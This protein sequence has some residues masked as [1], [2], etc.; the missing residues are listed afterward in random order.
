M[1]LWGCGCSKSIHACWF[2]AAANFYSVYNLA[3]SF[4]FSSVPCFVTSV[5]KSSLFVPAKV[6]ADNLVFA[7]MVLSRGYYSVA[8]QDLASHKAGAATQV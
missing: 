7:L 6:K 5:L 2:L 1:T 8:V 4:R 3:V